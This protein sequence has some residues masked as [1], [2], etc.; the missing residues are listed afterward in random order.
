V[1]SYLPVSIGYLA[2]ALVFATFWMR[3]PVRLRQVAI[4]SNVVFFIYGILMAAWPIAI[5]H[6]I[7]LPLNLL[8]LRELRDLIK[9][10]Q[11]A[12]TGDLNMD[13]L[14]PFM[15][16]RKFAAGE[17]I[18]HKGDSQIDVLYIVSGNVRLPEIEVAVGTGE[19]IGEMAIF[20]QE[21]ERSLSALCVTDVE[22]LHMP[23]DAF[24]KLYFQNH[25]FGLFLVRLITRRL[26]QDTQLLGSMI[27]ERNSQLERLR[28]HTD[29]DEA[30]GIANRRA[31]EARL[32][33][34][35]SRALR[36]PAPLSL[37]VARIE[38]RHGRAW[39]DEVLAAV[40]LA[41]GSC[42]SRASDLLARYDGEFVA[43]LPNTAQGAKPIADEMAR[44]IAD[45]EVPTASISAGDL[46]LSSGLATRTPQKDIPS[47]VLL[48]EAYR[49]LAGAGDMLASA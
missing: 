38:D 11:A 36:T 15:Q 1:I 17:Y 13:W 5:L 41:L 4:A 23:A 48:E 45:L 28:F 10:V 16:S 31:C 27:N 24:L 21:K 49:D 39:S 35:W 22:V 42:A 7:L 25:E 19:L 8:R 30:T 43:I 40:A 44:A 46:Y 12:L 2:S 26:L 32:N 34:E 18:F 37:I 3:T 6:A 47:K 33:M 9:K 20:S 29:V 14:R